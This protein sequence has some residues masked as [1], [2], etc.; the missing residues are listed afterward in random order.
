MLA[1]FEAPQKVL[2]EKGAETVKLSAPTSEKTS[3][4]A[5]GTIFASEQKLPL[6]VLAKGK[7]PRSEHKFGA[8]P[9]VIL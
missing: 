8:N 2:A 7:T 5:L 1:P 6:W 3:F 4:T 9:G